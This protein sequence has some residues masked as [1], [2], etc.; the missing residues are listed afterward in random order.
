M[1]SFLYFSFMISLSLFM[2][3]V[4]FGGVIYYRV[5]EIKRLPVD[6]EIDINQINFK[7]YISDLPQNPYI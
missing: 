4:F 6:K 3:F 2:L 1:F 5:F 7:N